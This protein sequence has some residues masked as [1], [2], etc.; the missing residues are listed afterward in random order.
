MSCADEVNSI[1][2]F[3]LTDTEGDMFVLF[4]SH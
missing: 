1:Y 3:C 2:L 4:D